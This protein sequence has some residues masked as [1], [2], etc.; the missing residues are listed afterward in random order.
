MLTVFVWDSYGTQ[1]LYNIEHETRLNFVNWQLH[2]AHGGEINHTI[3]L[4]SSETCFQVSRCMSC[5]DKMF[6]MLILC[7]VA[8]SLVCGA[9]YIQLGLLASIPHLFFFET[10]NSLFFYLFMYLASCMYNYPDQQMHNLYIVT[11]FYMSQ[12]LLHVSM[13]L[14]YLQESYPSTLLKLQK[15]LGLQTQ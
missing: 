7:C 13:H 3:I 5:H 11:I 4:F 12:V 10:V 2:G 15:S 8:L 14:H 1:T 9:L 6:P